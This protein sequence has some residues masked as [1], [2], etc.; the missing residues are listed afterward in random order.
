MT[1]SQLLDSLNFR[2]ATKKFDATRQIPAEEWDTLEKSLVL[3]PSSFGL[4]PWKFLVV[5]SPDL[6]LR[7]Q[8]H[9]WNQSQITDASRLVVFTT[10]TDTT[11][12]DVDR[13]MSR[14]AAVQGR[15]A[16]S[17]EGYRNIIVSF[18]STMSREARHAWNARQTYI[19]LGQFMTSAA[20]L[21]IDTCPIE[22]FDP[23]GY[24]AELELADSGYATSVVCAV[25]YRSP[26]DKYAETPK[27]RFPHEE[28]VEHR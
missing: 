21:G 7:L 16:S 10:R 26:E 8:K 9:S 5:D 25:G 23:A 14:L 2:Y 15:D 4:Q 1:P 11:E 3:T 20:V 19:A 17:L 28:L 27:T 18:A 12:P 13:F 24:D 22:G 6:R